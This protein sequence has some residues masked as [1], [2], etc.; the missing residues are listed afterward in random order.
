MKLETERLILRDYVEDDWHDVL[1]YQSHPRSME[2]YEWD[3]RTAEDAQKFVQMFL[4]QQQVKPRIKFQLA[5]TLKSDHR[6]IGSCGLRTDKSAATEGDI[7]F[8]ISPELWGKGLATEAA[9]AI[10]RFGFDEL[11][12]HRVWS[13]CIAENVG[14]SKVL[15]K[16]GLQL[17]GRLREKDYFKGRWW[18]TLTYGILEHEWRALQQ[19]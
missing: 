8:E 6:L 14:S 19:T 3:E 9:Q 11:K 10:V 1:A 7:G 17:E 2:F 5:V 18:D 16:L 4:D 13:W 15:E 12:L